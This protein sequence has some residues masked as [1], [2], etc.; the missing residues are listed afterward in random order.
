MFDRLPPHD[1]CVGA[2]V[3]IEEDE[4]PC[5]VITYSLNADSGPANVHHDGRGTGV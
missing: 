2:W 3:P 1:I 5:L 4:E